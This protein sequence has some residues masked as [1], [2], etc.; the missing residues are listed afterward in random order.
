MTTDPHKN[1]NGW[2]I[3]TLRESTQQQIADLKILLDERY[4]GRSNGI[5]SVM[6]T[7]LTAAGLLVAIVV[8]VIT[9]VAS[10]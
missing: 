10:R 5:S 4:A 6:A 8:A 7:G 3:G 9:I 2:T 1:E